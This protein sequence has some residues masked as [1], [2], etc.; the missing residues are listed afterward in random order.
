MKLTKVTSA[1]TALF[2]AAVLGT[3]AHAQNLTYNEGDL[4]IGFENGGGSD[5]VVDLDRYPK[6][7][8]APLEAP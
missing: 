6:S 1:L 4:L 2:V 8:T 5:Y 7:S 3:S